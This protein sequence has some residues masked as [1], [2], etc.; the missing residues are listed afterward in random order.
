M[1]I[2][3]YKTTRNRLGGKKELEILDVSNNKKY[4]VEV[5]KNNQC[6]KSYKKPTFKVILFKFL[7]KLL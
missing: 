2:L 6:K 1:S 7:G 4:K 5:I 3:K